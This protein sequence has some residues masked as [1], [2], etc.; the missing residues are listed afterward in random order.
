M[1]DVKTKWDFRDFWVVALTIACLVLAL[2][3]LLLLFGAGE[4]FEKSKSKSLIMLVLFFVQE[5]IFILPLYFLIIKKYKLK[6]VDLGARGIG[7][8]EASKWILGGLGIFILFNIIFALFLSGGGTD[9]PGFD[10]QKPFMP[11]FGSEPL[12]LTIA[13]VVLVFI[14]PVVEELVFRGFVLQT[15][16]AKF[17]PVYA[18]LISAGIFSAVHFEFQSVGIIFALALILNWIFMRSKSLW[19]CIGFHMLNNALVFLVEI[20]LYK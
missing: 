19:P 5:V 4:F 7:F 11:L 9:L 1:N 14:A 3:I 20:L 17:K 18:T 10:Q 2:N 13:I 16:L 15:F 6:L 12:D 8:I